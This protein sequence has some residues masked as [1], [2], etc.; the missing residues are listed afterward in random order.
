MT[1]DVIRHTDGAFAVVSRNAV[2][3]SDRVFLFH[4]SLQVGWLM[5]LVQFG[6]NKPA[7]TRPSRAKLLE[8]FAASLI[9]GL[10]RPRNTSITAVQMLDNTPTLR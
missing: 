2:F 1:E 7:I 8:C 3:E 6:A 4:S 9:V 5:G 10:F